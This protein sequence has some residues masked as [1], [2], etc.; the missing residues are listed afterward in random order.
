M[1]PESFLRQP[2]RWLKAITKYRAA[3]SSAPNFAY[4]LCVDRIQAAELTEV[5]LSG[6]RVATNAAE[7]VRADVVERFTRRFAAYGFQP[8]A[9][10]P[11]YGLAEATLF[12]SGYRDAGPPLQLELA[13]S[14]LDLG[15]A[16]PPAM[17]QDA[18]RLLSCG[19]IATRSRVDIVDPQGATLA[20]REIGEICV[21]GRSVARGY[22]RDEQRTHETFQR[23]DG[24]NPRLRTG[25]LGFMHD[26]Q[27][28]VTGRIKDLI[29]VDGRN[30]YPH[31]VE[32]SVAKCLGLP[33]I[34]RGAKP[35][36]S[37]SKFKS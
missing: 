6:W 10:T 3:Y 11:S 36:R 13:R 14:Q 37:R 28:F 30:V 21:S 17:E 34:A 12:V 29:I 22:W 4:E 15:K 1:R 35:S 5:D 18:V 7:P 27:L 2:A 9:M 24:A 25:D 23:Q 32:A 26:G 19:R 33:S 8:N 16:L 20:E 31:D